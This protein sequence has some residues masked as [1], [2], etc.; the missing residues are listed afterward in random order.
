[1][2]S[3]KDLIE[4]FMHRQVPIS[5]NPAAK[6]EALVATVFGTKQRRFGPMPS[7][8]IQVVVRD[9]I[10]ASGDKL[11]FFLPWGSRKQADG[12]GLDVMEFM[13][14]QQLYCLK[15]E[16]LQQGIKSEYHFR[17]EDLTDGFLF[18]DHEGSQ[19][20]SLDYMVKFA[21]LSKRV[22]GDVVLHQE[23]LSATTTEFSE[24]TQKYALVFFDYI[25]GRK[26]AAALK[27][28]GWTGTLPAEQQ[29]YYLSAYRGYWPNKPL[30]DLQWE[31]AK[32]FGATLARVKLGATGAPK[33][34]HLLI[35]FTHPVP[36]NPVS[37]TR[38]HYRTIPQRFTNNHRSPWI[39][40]G[41]FEIAE[42]NSVTPKSAGVNE[43]LQ[44][45]KN[46][47]DLDGIKVEADYVLA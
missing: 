15:H 21:A 14:M 20:Q 10:R 38:L 40:K 22:L 19:Q 33:E 5:T 3:Y 4:T 46:V 31:M 26:T 30:T 44:F 17:L 25:A 24:L 34:P 47:I 16:L 9:V 39:G 43:K 35:A 41:Y 11:T 18:Y 42:D 7:P 2:D 13:A 12:Q 37:K 8:E 23:S 32:Y 36:G 28:I 1:M 29:E 6:F 45:E 27:E